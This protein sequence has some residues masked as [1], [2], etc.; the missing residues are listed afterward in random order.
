MFFFVNQI[1]H[2][3]ENS[4]SNLFLPENCLKKQPSYSSPLLERTAIILPPSF[5]VSPA[6]RLDTHGF[7]SML[8]FLSQSARFELCGLKMVLF[9]ED[10]AGELAL[11]LSLGEKV[12]L[13]TDHT[14]TSCKETK[15]ATLFHDQIKV[16]LEEELMVFRD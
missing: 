6:E 10:A 16:E 13:Y 7:I 4:F 9:S 11:R 1:K 14:C 2:L 3:T 15:I 8:E 5:L 12:V